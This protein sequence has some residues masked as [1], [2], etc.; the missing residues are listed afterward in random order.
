MS[1]LPGLIIVITD[2]RRVRFVRPGPDNALHTTQTVEFAA[3]TT[4][5]SRSDGQP[6]PATTRRPRARRRPGQASASGEP[7]Q[8]PFAH[9][10][11]G[12]LAEDF[13]VDRFTD[14]VLVAPADVLRDVTAAL[15]PPTGVTVIGSLARNLIDVPDLELW[16][17]L[18]TWVPPLRGK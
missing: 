14:L 11:A 2:G 1:D 16:P 13:A 10:L 4:D 9:R 3:G 15:D 12:R 18:R 6:K 5:P 17:R 8:L 7:H